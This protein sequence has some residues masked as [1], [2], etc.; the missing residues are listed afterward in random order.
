MQSPA[1]APAA[2]AVILFQLPAWAQT[3]TVLSLP[4][5]QEVAGIAPQLVAFAGSQSNFDN[6]VNGLALG[7][8]VTLSTTL[9]NG[10]TQLVTFT[11]SGGP[12]AITPIARTLAGARQSL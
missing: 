10:S 12:P 8:P 7:V 2:A 4:P 3:S 11:P 5:S 1:A 9:P 6:L